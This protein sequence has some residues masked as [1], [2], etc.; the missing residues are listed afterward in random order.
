MFYIGIHT[1]TKHFLKFSK[2]LLYQSEIY[3]LNISEFFKLNE[4]PET[5]RYARLFP[6]SNE[7]RMSMSVVG[8][9]YC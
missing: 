2:T 7:Q 9:V 1:S 3:K 6:K 8:T 4:I 5:T